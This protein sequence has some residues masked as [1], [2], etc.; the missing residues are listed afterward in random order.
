M[1]LETLTLYLLAPML[2]WAPPSWHAWKN[3]TPQYVEARYTEIA[4]DVAEVVSEEEPLEV[5]A[6]EQRGV[7]QAHTGLLL[8][9]IASYESGGFRSD[10]DRHEKKGD[11]GH[12]VCILQVWLRS[13]EHVRS[14]HECI[15]LGLARV[16]ESLAA[17]HSPDPGARL[18]VY[19]SGKCSTG[20]AEAK[21]RWNRQQEWWQ[22]APWFGLLDNTDEEWLDD[23]DP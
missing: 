6:D 20:I 17:C 7:A 4:Q 10:V 18:A 8:L 21:R 23:R 22:K 1:T 11:A 3:E 2:A 12:S 14:R 15:E 16:R 9:A 13:G 19:A 5:F